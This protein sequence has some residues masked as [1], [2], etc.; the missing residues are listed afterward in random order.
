MKKIEIKL[1]ESKF[2]ACSYGVKN[3]EIKNF[4]SLV[5]E[6]AIID[7][8][9]E[10]YF[11]V[12]QDSGDVSYEYGSAEFALMTQIIDVFTNI[13]V[14]EEDGGE[15]TNLVINVAS[16]DVEGLFSV[17]SEEIENYGSFR[18]RLDRTVCDA[19]EI[20]SYQRSLESKVNGLLENVSSFLLKIAEDITSDNIENIKESL[21]SL[22]KEVEDSPLKG[23]MEEVK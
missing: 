19:K 8:Y 23:I 10:N 5:E 22:A 4:I 1:K 11:E 12:N 2:Q 17:V 14:I 16:G 18:A 21:T 7:D 9:L 6:T 20:L 3:I 15:K 13:K